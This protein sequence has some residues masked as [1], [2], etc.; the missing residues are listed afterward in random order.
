MIRWQKK[1]AFE[2]SGLRRAMTLLELLIATAL[3]VVLMAA[4]SASL[5]MFMQF[6][7]RASD[8]QQSAAINRGLAEDLATDLRLALRPPVEDPAPEA[9]PQTVE[10]ERFSS[11]LLQRELLDLDS[12]MIGN[13][14][15]VAQDPI[16]FAGGTDWL[17]LLSRI[18][19]ARFDRK[20]GAGGEMRHVLWWSGNRMTVQTGSR[21]R[22][23]IRR[24]VPAVSGKP[25]LW[26]GLIPFGG[27]NTAPLPPPVV[28][29]PQ[30]RS[31]KF[32]YRDGYRWLPEWDSDESR[33]L[34]TAVECTPVWADGRAGFPMTISLPLARS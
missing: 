28:V 23:Q 7:S 21:D 27:R 34:P 3:S 33:E 4:V 26:R 8:G 2:R 13:G 31:V 14:D 24:T 29:T 19:N 12:G 32:R 10:D 6:R 20:K 15:A 1:T 18:G 17:M 25:G 5:D 16:Y 11:L 30:I 9:K 22:L